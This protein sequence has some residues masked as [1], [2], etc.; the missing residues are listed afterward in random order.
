MKKIKVVFSSEMPKK[1]QKVVNKEG[2]NLKEV[3]PPASIIFT[4]SVAGLL[5]AYY[6]YKNI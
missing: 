6:I 5:C 3:M 2:K 1:Q 4:P